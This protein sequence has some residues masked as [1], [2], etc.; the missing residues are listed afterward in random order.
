MDHHIPDAGQPDEDVNHG[1]G[2][3]G[4]R[5]P[6]TLKN[7]HSQ[8]GGAQLLRISASGSAAIRATCNVTAGAGYSP[9]GTADDRWTD[10]PMMWLSLMWGTG[11]RSLPGR[12]LRCQRQLFPWPLAVTALTHRWEIRRG[13]DEVFRCPARSVMFW[14]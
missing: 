6:T 8:P 7:S 13:S 11:E 4:D 2:D 1:L 5:L 10:V 3:Y 9:P 14:R 12:T